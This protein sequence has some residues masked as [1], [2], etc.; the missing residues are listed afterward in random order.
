MTIQRRDAIR[1]E[2]G[3]AGADALLVTKLV[4]VRYLTGFSGSNAQLLLGAGDVLFSDGR[5]ETQSAREAP[6]VERV[7]YSGGVGFA[8][9]LAEVIAAREVRRLAVEAHHMTLHT[10]QLVRRASPGVEVVETT[11]LIERQRVVKTAEEI[12]AVGKACAIGDAGFEA[13]LGRLT[14]GMSEVDAA[15]ELDDAMR[16]AGSEGLSFDTIVAFGE[17]AAEPHHRPG[18]ERRLRNGDLVKL[19]FGATWGGYHSDMTR[20]VAFGAPGDEQRRIYSIVFD[21]Q[22]AGL[23][24]VRA[25]ATCSGV[26]SA[27]RDVVEAAG[28]GFGHGVGHGVGLEVHEAPSVR[29]ESVEVLSPGMIVTVEPGIYLPGFAGVRIE[30]TVAVTPVGHQVLTHSPKELIQV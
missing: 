30:D 7:I 25:G 16:R 17:S 2:L 9:T 8:S 11:G 12:A 10:A 29:K 4:N 15:A 1:A 5:Y 13:L 3:E 26:D 6:D 22:R 23:E 20:T 14:E 19:D 28:F 18:E 27:S 24:A 21:A